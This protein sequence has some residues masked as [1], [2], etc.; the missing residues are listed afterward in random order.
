MAGINEVIVRL[1]ADMR[2]F[3]AKIGEAGTTVKE[4]GKEADTMGGKW[5]SLGSKM[6]T[7]VLVG[8]GGALA[9]G[10]EQA[11]KFN[12][13]LDAIINQ[14]GASAEEVDYLKKKII[15]VSNATGY[16]ADSLSGAALQ[17]EKAGIRGKAAYDLLSNAA[18]GARITGGQ[19]ADITKTIIGVQTL[20]IAK[21][22]SVAQI[23]ETLVQANKMHLGSLD[24]LTQVLSGK[25]GAALAT[26]GVNLN[27]AA[28]VAGI[29]SKAGITN[30]RSM[31]SLA[32][33]L[34]ALENPTKAQDKALHAL[35]LS[36]AGLTSEMHKPD[37]L[38]QVLK[39]LADTAQKTGKPVGEIAAQI[40]GKGGAGTA[41]V[42]INNIKDLSSAYKTLAGSNPSTLQAQFQQTMTQLGPQ[43]QKAGANFN[44]A[45][46]NVGELILPGVSKLAGWVAS[47]ASAIN[48]NKAL[49]DVLGGTLFA[50]VVLSVAVKLKSAFDAVKS[51]FGAGKDA[52]Q[53]AQTQTMITLLETANGWLE[54]IAL[55]TA[56][57]DAELAVADT[58]LA[59]EGGGGKPSVPKKI[60]DVGKKLLP[61]V[62]R[63]AVTDVLP[64]VGKVAGSTALVGV[65]GTVLANILQASGGAY[66]SMNQ[67]S[68]KK[69]WGAA[70]AMPQLAGQMQI[71]AA[72]GD[73]YAY[74]S[75][76][77]VKQLQAD[78]TKM[79]AANKGVLNKADYYKVVQGLAVADMPNIPAYKTQMANTVASGGTVQVTVK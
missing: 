55:S 65:Y 54:K 32:N 29:A 13:S 53:S 7:G 8:V 18:M 5:K 36:S 62:A 1:V 48:S 56:S 67:P 9:Y 33:S 42:L 50:G 3:N 25:V 31:V 15:D 79:K 40:F 35:G 27:E 23:T 22:E 58:E 61:T 63:T 39:T 49:R 47:F 20:Q 52:V 77:Q 66:N 17:I 46:L 75:M 68:F 44:N 45:L 4:F 57:A 14:S 64:E 72:P 69:P 78:I 43:L 2:E 41:T 21:G 16:S 74:I 12:E 11:Y 60:I 30:S 73:N 76:A 26:Y 71:Q 51:L 28:A 24:S 6:S 19:V 70:G 10:T 37:G 59:K 38:I 34:G